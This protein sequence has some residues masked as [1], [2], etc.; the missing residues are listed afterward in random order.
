[1]T[2]TAFSSLSEPVLKDAL[3]KGSIAALISNMRRNS[4]LSKRDFANKS[5]VSTKT[6]SRLENLEYDLTVSELLSIMG[7][8]GVEVDITL[9][10]NSITSSPIS[11][12]DEECSD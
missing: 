4:E 12:K 7:R 10:G 6:I 8:L 2:A 5:G 3:V 9:N 1:M 11:H